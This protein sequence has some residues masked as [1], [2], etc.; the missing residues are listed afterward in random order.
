MER[1]GSNQ[2]PDQFLFSELE[3]T[4][5]FTYPI[6][7]DISYD[8]YLGYWGVGMLNGSVKL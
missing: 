5:G 1:K 2:K 7:T 4:L 6:C 8:Q 3:S